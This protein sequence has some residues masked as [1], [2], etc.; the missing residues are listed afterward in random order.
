VPGFGK[1]F[2][3]FFCIMQIT[4]K[5]NWAIWEK[6]K[7]GEQTETYSE[8]EINCHRKS[9]RSCLVLVKRLTVLEQIGYVEP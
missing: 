5:C 7:G 9:H 1:K 4:L 3:R 6:R 2:N 8:G